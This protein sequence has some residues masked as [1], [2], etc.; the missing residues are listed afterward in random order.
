MCF[1]KKY[2]KLKAIKND[3]KLSNPSLFPIRLSDNEINFLLRN[4]NEKKGGGKGIN[5]YLEFGSGGSTFLSIMNTNA[6]VYSVESDL[7]WINYLR[8][9]KIIN[10]NENKRLFFNYID[11]GNVGEWGI[12]LEKD[13]EFL[14]EN[15]SKYIFNIKKDFDLVFIDG[16][17]RIACVLQVLL[18]CQNNTK[19]IIHDFNDRPN[20]HSILNFLDIIDTAD[21]MALFK[22]KNNNDINKIEDLYNKEKNNYE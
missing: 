4:L 11:I 20:Y 15:Y 9:W 10:E 3:Q 14:Y 18:N 2:K 5:N 13:K 22:I 6:N 1:L 17:F 7:N 19:I 12:P 16:R 8:K 21:T